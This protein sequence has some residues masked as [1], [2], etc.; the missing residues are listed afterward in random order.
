MDHDPRRIDT[1]DYEESKREL[2]QGEKRDKAAVMRIEYI[3]LLRENGLEIEIEVFS[4]I[5]SLIFLV[6]TSYGQEY[7]AISVCSRKCFQTGLHAFN[8]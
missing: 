8:L 1:E 4:L 6:L 3:K 5:F 7:L 2:K